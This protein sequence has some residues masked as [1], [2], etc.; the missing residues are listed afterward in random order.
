MGAAGRA[1]AHRGRE[2][3]GMRSWRLTVGLRPLVGAALDRSEVA[4]VDTVRMEL[5][6]ALR[7]ESMGAAVRSWNRWGKRTAAGHRVSG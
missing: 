4:Y 6:L 2:V 7:M 5:L 3:A 1:G